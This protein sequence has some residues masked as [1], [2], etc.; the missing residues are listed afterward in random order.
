MS[1]KWRPTTKYVVGIC[2]TLLF[3]VI[4]YISRSVI[5]LLII[6]ALIA[7]LIKP[8]I[9]YLNHRVRIPKG[10]AVFIAH[11]LAAILILLAPL[12]L[13]PTI[14]NA[15]NF[16][17]NLD[18][19][20]LIDDSLL[21]F[22]STLINLKESDLQILGYKFI[23]DSIIDPVLNSIHNVD[24]VIS[25]GLPSY[26]VILDSITSAFAVSY[27]I[28]VSVVGTV[29]SVVV[30]LFF[31]FI[32]SIYLSS[33]SDRL[34][35]SAMNYLPASY[36]PEFNTLLNRLN[37]V[38]RSFLRG[39]FSLMLI[40][41]FFVWIGGTAIGLPGA[42]ALGVI[43]GLL[44]IIPN[45]GPILATI[46]AIFVALIQGSTVLPVNNVTFVVIVI[47]FYMLV[48]GLENYLIVPR[49]L[50]EAVKI[51]PMVVIFGVFVGASV[52][53]IL[54]ALLAAPVIASGKEIMSY[55]LRKIMDQDPFPPEEKI[56]TTDRSTLERINQ[57]KNRLQSINF[58]RTISST[59][60]KEE[61]SEKS[62]K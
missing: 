36:R 48:Q 30:A 31:M 5:Y 59:Q 22:E 58:K 40:I 14:V 7:F 1:T 39:Q 53:G 16:L 42:F 45:L 32:A 11:L 13:I 35:L 6:G 27:G 19:Q 55:L 12:V 33:D 54:G 62:D 47:V 38:W 41:G 15:V 26:P 44:E 18:Y 34:Y 43:A 56:P 46:P 20:L 49:V 10:L 8:L 25:P 24:P 29:F 4:I 57:I 60:K 28:A 52:G 50:G 3:F 61:L 17:L 51:H 2:I 23:L 21:W 9:D 37:F